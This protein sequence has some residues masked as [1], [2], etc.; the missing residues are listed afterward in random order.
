MSDTTK[1]TDGD[2]SLRQ[3]PVTDESTD[4]AAPTPAGS[5]GESTDSE[6]AESTSDV[7]TADGEKMPHEFVFAFDTWKGLT[8]CTLLLTATVLAIA[9]MSELSGWWFAASVP[10]MIIAAFAAV[11]FARINYLTTACWMSKS[12]N[13]TVRVYHRPISYALWFTYF[14]VYYVVL[15]WTEVMGEPWLWRE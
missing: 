14:A 12:S 10:L 3:D 4:A 7:E 11:L 2:A 5:N 1:T 15:R 8:I 9:V 13:E 6:A